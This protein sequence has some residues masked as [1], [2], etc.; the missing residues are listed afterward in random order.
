MTNSNM[1]VITHSLQKVILFKKIR[2]EKYRQ[3]KINAIKTDVYQNVV[4]YY[5][6][7]LTKDI[8]EQ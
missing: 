3:Q 7:S 4:V 8:I 5:D 1:K 6:Q 2:F